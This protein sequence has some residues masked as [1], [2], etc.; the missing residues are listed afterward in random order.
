MRMCPG[1]PPRWYTYTMTVLTVGSVYVELGPKWVLI[2]ERLLGGR[3]AEAVRQRWLWMDGR[4][5]KGP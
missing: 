3:T 1:V 5:A 4:V 2:A